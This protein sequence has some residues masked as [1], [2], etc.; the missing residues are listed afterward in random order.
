MSRYGVLIVDDSAFMRRA[1][2]L[3]FDE[4]PDFYVV[5]IARNGAEAVEKVNRLKPDIVT[6]DVEMPEMDGIEALKIIMADH[7]V[8]VVMLS[9][10][11]DHGTEATIKALEHGAVDFFLKDHLIGG[12]GQAGEHK[13]FLERVKCVAQAKPSGI[14]RQG[15]PAEIPSVELASRRPAVDL[16]LIGSSTGGPSA[17]QS[18]LLRFPAT[19]PIPVLVVQHMPAGFTK[20]LADRFNNLCPITIKEA[21]NGEVPAP[22][23]V[24]VAPAGFQTQVVRQKDGVVLLTVAGDTM[25]RYLYKPSIDA[26]LT[27]AVPVYGRRILTVILTGMGTDGTAGCREL[28]K[29]KG[30]VLAEA[31]ESCVVYGMPRSVHEAGLTDRQVPLHQIYENLIDMAFEG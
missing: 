4:D 10:Q 14:E 16:I 31:E 18:I 2:H 29:M 28:K 20:P 22:G 25:G 13:T 30:R 12:D 1:I 21:E 17:L 11:T 24:Y 3:L 6:M 7:P 26:A 19:F 23:N 15:R 27:S 5:G 9:V 8:P